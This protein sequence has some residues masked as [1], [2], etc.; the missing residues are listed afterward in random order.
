[1]Y[2]SYWRELGVRIV[3]VSGSPNDKVNK[4]CR[5]WY[6]TVPPGGEPVSNPKQLDESFFTKRKKDVVVFDYGDSGK[7]AYIAVQV[8]NDGKEGPW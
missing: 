8:E 2:G 7:T 1:L 6:K 5:I 3:Y 4:G